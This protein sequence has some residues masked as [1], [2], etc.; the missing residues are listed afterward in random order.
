MPP[1]RVAVPLVLLLAPLLGGCLEA[2]DGGDPQGGAPP[3]TGTPTPPATATPTAPSPAPTPATTQA[4]PTPVA[5]AQPTPATAPTAD[6]SGAHVA[7]RD[8]AS[9]GHSNATQPARLVLS[10]QA[11]YEAFW[12]GTLN[13]GEAPPAVDF[14]RERVVAALLGS[15]PNTCWS[16]RVTQ[17]EREDGQVEVRVVTYAPGPGMMCGQAFTQPYHVVAIAS[18]DEPV[19]FDERSETRS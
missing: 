17:A 9:G 15:K 13:T 16:V 12:R 5:S 8:L 1:S 14:S 7:V 10:T 18:V 2:Q 4:T 11:E 19:T 3:A 6:A